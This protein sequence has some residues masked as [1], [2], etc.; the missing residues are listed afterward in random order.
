[1]N[2]HKLISEIEGQLYSEDKFN[3]D[4]VLLNWIELISYLD[5]SKFN[6]NF[7]NNELIVKHKAF[8]KKAKITFQ[9]YF[10]INNTQ[11]EI[12]NINKELLTLLTK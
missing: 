4:L 8:N 3:Y 11:F 10:Y 5:L 1:M 7:V 6:V 12:D 2:K 9:N